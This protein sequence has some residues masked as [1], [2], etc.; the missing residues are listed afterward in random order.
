MSSPESVKSSFFRKSRRLAT[1]LMVRVSARLEAGEM[2]AAFVGVDVVHEGEGVLVV[3]VLVLQGEVHVHVVLDRVECDGLGVER[4]LVPV[5]PLD[6]LDQAALG[7][8]GLR[9]WAAAP[10]HP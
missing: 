7:K 10:A 8:E 6:E 9:S 1:S 5:E 3:S 4:L 2:G